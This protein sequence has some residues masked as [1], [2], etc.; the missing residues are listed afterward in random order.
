MNDKDV[1]TRFALLKAE[2]D[3]PSA[4]ERCLEMAEQGDYHGLLREYDGP[5]QRTHT[6]QQRISWLH[7]ALEVAAHSDPAAFSGR[8]F[9]DMAAFAAL[10]VLRARRTFERIISQIDD[11]V[12]PDI[13]NHLLHQ[14]PAHDALIALRE[15]QEHTANI[16]HAAAATARSWQLA[17]QHQKLE[18][19]RVALPK[20]SR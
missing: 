14:G 18:G 12:G 4:E 5:M 3:Q 1:E 19:T 16:L 6:A 2:A 17:L 8:F 13:N 15:T 10:T 9:A 11:S 20:K 7:R